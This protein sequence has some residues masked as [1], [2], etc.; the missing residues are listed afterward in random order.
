[1]MSRGCPVEFV[2]FTLDCAQSDHAIA[3]AHALCE[4][5][6]HGVDPPVHVVEFQ[7]VKDALIEAV[8]YLPGGY[9]VEYGRSLGGVLHL[10]G[11]AHLSLLYRGSQ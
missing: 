9:G 3:V 1:M 6:G 7:P 10:L 2:H 11:L 5:W 4:R 8:D